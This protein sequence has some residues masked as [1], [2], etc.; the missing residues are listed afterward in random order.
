MSAGHA[1]V[2]NVETLDADEGYDNTTGIYTAKTAGVYLFTW[3]VLGN[4]GA[5]VTSWLMVNSHR[6]SSAWSE[7]KDSSVEASSTNTAL[8]HI[9]TGDRV[10]IQ[11]HNSVSIYS[12]PSVG[13]CSFSGFLL[14]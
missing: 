8:I 7:D 13:V 2:F 3:T 12:E 1:I 6:I 5:D 4:A 10:L 14:R 9:N 11:T